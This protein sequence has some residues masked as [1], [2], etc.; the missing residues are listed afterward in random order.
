MSFK[1]IIS[2]FKYSCN[3]NHF[4]TVWK[5]LTSYP[6]DYGYTYDIMRLRLVEQC[7]YFKKSNISA[8]SNYIKSRI[9]LALRLYDI[10]MG[11]N[12]TGEFVGGLLDAKYVST[13][14]VNTKN[15]HRF[16]PKE[17]E[18]IFN[19]YPTFL[20]EEKAYQLFWKIM[21]HNSREWW[22]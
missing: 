3:K 18:E 4:R 11:D 5:T 21:K 7:E 20:Y 16:G 6:W 22:D 14:Y 15:A 12:G 19:R 10:M 13:K 8:D 17:C 9:E 1:S 2:W